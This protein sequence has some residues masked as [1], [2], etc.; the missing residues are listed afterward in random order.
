MQH[1]DLKQ[2][3]K[4]FV[5]TSI[6][7][8][9]YVDS[10]KRQRSQWNAIL[11]ESK[12][13]IRE[14]KSD[15]EAEYWIAEDGSVGS[16]SFRTSKSNK[17]LKPQNIEDAISELEEEDLVFDMAAD[18]EA[19]IE[20]LTG[21]L[22]RQI[23]SLRTSVNHT[24]HVSLT[25]AP[26]KHKLTLATRRTAAEEIAAA[27]KQ[28]HDAQMEIKS[29]AIQAKED[30]ARLDARLDECR[31][32]IKQLFQTSQ[33]RSQKVHAPQD[34]STYFVRLKDPKRKMPTKLSTTNLSAVIREVLLDLLPE[35]ADSAKAFMAIRDDLIRLLIE[36]TVEQKHEDQETKDESD[37]HERGDEERLVLERSTAPKTKK[38]KVDTVETVETVDTMDPST[39]E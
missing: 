1:M 10:V 5:E 9:R 29:I 34:G 20:H 6:E 32:R 17:S 16:V 22:T 26:T 25:T 39:M 33:V 36:R 19:Y 37:T 2:C 14:L 24:P 11:K 7:R 23:D 12:A 4:T 28:I 3:F 27:A 31:P 8:Q 21:I 18:R 38:R 13:R 15:Y 30:L 35:T